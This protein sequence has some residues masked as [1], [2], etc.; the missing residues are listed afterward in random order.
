TWTLDRAC[1]TGVGAA[2]TGNMG[3]CFLTL[4]EGC[5]A[6]GPMVAGNTT[7]VKQG[8]YLTTTAIA[9]VSGAIG[10]HCIIKGYNATR[11]DLDNVNNYANFPSIVANNVLITVISSN[12]SYIDIWNLSVSGGTGATK[13][14]R[15]LSVTGSEISC[16][17]CSASGFTA[18]GIYVLSGLAVRCYA[19]SCPIGIESNA[20]NMLNCIATACTT[21]GIEYRGSGAI[22]NC[23]AINNTGDGIAAVGTYTTQALI[24]NCVSDSNSGNGM[25]FSAVTGPSVF[26]IQNCILSNNGTYGINFSGTVVPQYEVNNAF[27][28]NTSGQVSGFTKSASDIVLSST[29]YN[30]PGTDFSLNNNPGGGAACRAAG[31]PGVFPLANSTGYL[32]IG[33]IQSRS[34]GTAY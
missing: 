6:T 30:N 11:G 9:P 25:N 7:W 28:N 23:M 32:D 4:Q 16:I 21:A 13:G 19:T 33:A 18:F 31:Y 26:A 24:L 34:A 12:N 17:N 20:G 8:T 1:T 22:I 5:S 29:P 3:G 2:M 27:Y 15:G 10:A 14:S